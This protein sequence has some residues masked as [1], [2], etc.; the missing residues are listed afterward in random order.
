M[1][2]NLELLPLPS[3]SI[4]S[5]TIAWLRLARIYHKIDR[6]S[7]ETMGRHGISVSRFDV[8][9]HAGTPEG[10]TQQELARALLVTKGNITQLLDAM[11][12]TNPTLEGKRAALASCPAAT[13]ETCVTGLEGELA[14]AARS[15]LIATAVSLVGHNERAALLA[16]SRNVA[17]QVTY[18]G[19]DV[20]LTRM[21]EFAQ[22]TA[23]DTLLGH[24]ATT[25]RDALMIL[26]G[27]SL[28]PIAVDLKKE[29]Q[30][31]R[32][33]RRVNGQLMAMTY[34]QLAALMHESGG[35]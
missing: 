1:D 27:Q 14:S 25:E 8:L 9:N 12:A 33:E 31:L 16:P 6:R 15:S 19:E 13:L 29:K 32:F 17:L 21:L 20:G 26:S 5:S 35:P 7:A 23:L 24:T 4:P 30:G 10:R 2:T 18:R 22:K 34:A 11:E 3:T 28:F